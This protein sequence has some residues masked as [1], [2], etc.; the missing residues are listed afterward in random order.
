MIN[1]LTFSRVDRHEI[2]FRV[3]ENPQRRTA[4]DIARAI[5]ENR[6]KNNLLRRFGF[7]VVEAGVGDKTKMP[8][9]V[10]VIRAE[11]NQPDVTYILTYILLGAGAAALLVVILA[12]V[13][14]RRGERK[15]DKLG[16]LQAGLTSV[17]S[18]SKDYQDLC[19]TRMAAKVPAHERFGSVKE[20]GEKVQTSSRSS[21][22]SWSEEPATNMDISTGHMV[23]VRGR[24]TFLVENFLPDTVFI[25][26]IHSRIWRTT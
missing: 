10:S 23:L 6:T 14:V 4:A 5:N 18:N 12:V 1:Y 15:R 22:S 7:S 8:L 9:A 26:R 21:V 25:E 11:P 3:E 20:G 19:R 16:G 2:T 13:F 17:E 24:M